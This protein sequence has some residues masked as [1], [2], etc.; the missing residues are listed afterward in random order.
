MTYRAGRSQL[1]PI[2]AEF[3]DDTVA[4]LVECGEIFVGQRESCAGY[5]FA[6]MR[7]R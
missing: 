3:G 4:D 2:A 5:V 6:Q 7:R 1:L